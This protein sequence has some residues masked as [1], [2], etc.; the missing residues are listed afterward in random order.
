MEKENN[1]ELEKIMKEISKN[2]SDKPHKNKLAE[3]FNKD[4]NAVKNPH[5]TT[6]DI[7]TFYT[8]WGKK[9]VEFYGEFKQKAR[10]IS[11]LKPLIDYLDREGYQWI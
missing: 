4:N 8:E 5:T 3:I 10:S 7:C 1:K 2:F 6:N 9:Y 11:E